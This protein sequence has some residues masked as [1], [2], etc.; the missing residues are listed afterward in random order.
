MTRAKR[1]CV[2]FGTAL[3]LLAMLPSP[4]NASNASQVYFNDFDGGLTVA[5]G[6]TDTLGGITTTESVQGYD[7]L[8]TGSNTFAGNFLRNTTGGYAGGG[9][10]GTPGFP[11]TL[12]LTGLPPHISIDINF[13]LAIVDSWDGSEPGTGPGACTSCHPDIFTVIVD[14]N[15]V[16]SEAFGYWGPVFNPPPGVQLTENTPLGFNP[17]FDDAAYD[18]GFNPTFN[19]IPHTASTLTIEWVA[20]GD[21]WQGDDD[22]SWAIENLEVV[23]EVLSPLDVDIDIKPGSDPNSI[24]LKSKGIV[25]VAILTTEVFDATTVDPVTVLFAGASPLRWATED[26]DLDGDIDLVFFFQV[27]ELNLDEYSTEAMLEGETFSGQGLLGVDT[28]KIKQ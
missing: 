28:V 9:S 10:I 3:F 21:G 2:Y 18:M 15:T 25:P 7:G 14:G 4:T 24:N 17:N 23:L 8:G 13:L 27:Q 26:V 11:T 16:F 5:P 12:T 22:E 6:V 19:S 1:L 20:S